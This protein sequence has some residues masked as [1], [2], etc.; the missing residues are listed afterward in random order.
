MSSV[1]KHRKFSF[2]E[3]VGANNNKFWNI[4]EY[5]DGEI[6]VE[7]GRIGKTASSSLCEKI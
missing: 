2:V 6:L 4:T 3:F 7:F 1:V 5:D